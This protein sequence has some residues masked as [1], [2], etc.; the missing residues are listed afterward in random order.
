[1]LKEYADLFTGDPAWHE[2][3]Q[4]FSSRVRDVTEVLDGLELDDRIG[5]IDADV[6]YRSPVISR[7]RSASPRRRGGCS[8]RSP[9][10]VWWK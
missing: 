3:A 1:M 2:R 4:R 8:A 9:A 6:T 10:C 7:T 5:R